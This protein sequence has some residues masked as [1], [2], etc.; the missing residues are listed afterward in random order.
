MPV[1]SASSGINN[2]KVKE[3]A[4]KAAKETTFILRDSNN[5]LPISSDKK[6]LLIEQV[7]S[8]AAIIN[9]NHYHPG[10]MWRKFFE[11][12]EDVM[13]V[14][15]DMDYSEEDRARVLDRVEEADV[16][17]VTNFFGRR[18]GGGG[19]FVKELH[20]MK[21]GKPIVVVTN[22]PYPMTVSDEFETIVMTYANSPEAYEVV[23]KITLSE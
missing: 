7:P 14:E 10:I 5:T 2:P 21:L 3:I 11:L 22:N 18:A 17:V 6:I 12:N 16:L 20:E 8:L 4:E 15:V 19:N 9:Q 13:S 23:A 1:E